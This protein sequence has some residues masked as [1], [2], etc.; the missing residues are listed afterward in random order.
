M[1]MVREFLAKQLLR[2]KGNLSFSQ[3]GEDRI[4]KFIFN[5]LHVDQPTYLDIGAHDP[6]RL[7]NTYLLYLDG[8]RGVCIEPN[9]RRFRALKLARPRDVCIN[10]GLAGYQSEKRPFFIFES[11][12]L[13]TFSQTDAERYEREHNE[14]ISETVMVDIITPLDVRERHF[15]DPPDFVNLDVEGLEL[16]ILTALDLAHYRPAV[17]CVETISYATDGGGRKNE[18]IIRYLSQNGYL[19]YADTYIN[20]IFVDESQWRRHA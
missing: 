16:E 18:E 11:D 19:N 4:V 1:K 8:A 7:N 15:P 12:T 17:F 9:P 2:N 3:C 6:A 20:N 14:R 13:S 5:A 10:A